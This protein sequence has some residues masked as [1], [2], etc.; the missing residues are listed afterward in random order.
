MHAGLWPPLSRLS[1]LTALGAVHQ[2]AD[3]AADVPAQRLQL[4]SDIRI[5]RHVT[6]RGAVD[7]AIGQLRADH[8]NGS[9]HRSSCSLEIRALHHTTIGVLAGAAPAW[10]KT[11]PTTATI[12]KR[13][14]DAPG[15]TEVQTGPG[16]TLQGRKVRL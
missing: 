15:D 13:T 7:A 10:S 6:V 14:G 16:Q 12:A 3:Q 5:I 1:F 11:P 9:A 2:P 4:L 8:V